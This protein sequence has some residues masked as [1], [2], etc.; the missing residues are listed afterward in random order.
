MSNS[1]YDKNKL[2]T[3]IKP[4][5]VDEK[6]TLDVK[7]DGMIKQH[8][9]E[10][11][12]FKEK[13]VRYALFKMGWSSP[14]ERFHVL[15]DKKLRAENM[16]LKETL[17]NIAALSEYEWKVDIMNKIFKSAKETLSIIESK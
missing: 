12:D 3:T 6:L 8:Y 5:L 15:N 11:I 16:L 10:Q 17:K 1:I 2:N 4:S 13:T 7:I 14:C 9:Q